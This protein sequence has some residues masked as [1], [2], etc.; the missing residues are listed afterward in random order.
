M[1]N[2]IPPFLDHDSRISNAAV[3]MFCCYLDK[4]LLTNFAFNGGLGADKNHLKIASGIWTPL[5][6][7]GD[8]DPGWESPL[9]WAILILQNHDGRRR[10]QI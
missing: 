1:T 8:T 5:A 6:T 2:A 7:K 10:E 4:D 3:T 9:I